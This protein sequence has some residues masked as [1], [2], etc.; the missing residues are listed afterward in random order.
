M[1]S[2]QPPLLQG[3]L[4]GILARAESPDIGIERGSERGDRAMGGGGVVRP[5]LFLTSAAPINQLCAFPPVLCTPGSYCRTLS[6]LLSSYVY[7]HKRQ[8]ILLGH[9]NMVDSYG[10]GP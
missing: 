9:S 8:I 1:L 7:T 5:C 2:P 6:P 3:Q 4:G 10:S